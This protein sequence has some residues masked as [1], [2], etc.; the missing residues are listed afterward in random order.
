VLRRAAD[1]DAEPVFDSRRLDRSDLF[2]ATVLRPG[3]YRVSN[4]G[5]G[6]T[7]NL[8]VAYPE[9]GRGPLRPGEPVRVEVGQDFSPPEFTVEP[10]QGQV[11][12]IGAPARIRLDLV[13]PFDR[14]VEADRPRHR[15]ARRPR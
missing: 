6:A 15:R 5:T 2:T 11:Y 12:E 13:E 10:T 8:T 14:A 3:R 1:D 4:D 7:A 9:R